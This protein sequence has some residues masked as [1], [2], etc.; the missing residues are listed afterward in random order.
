MV[1]MIAGQATL[2]EDDGRHPMLPGDIAVW[3]KGSTNGHHLINESE[4]DCVFVA[5]GGG[6]A[7]DSG[8]GYSDIDMLFTPDGYTRKDGT[9]YETQRIA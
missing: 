2:V 7:Y 5:L 4:D 1:I 3:P 9:P 6:K 8:G